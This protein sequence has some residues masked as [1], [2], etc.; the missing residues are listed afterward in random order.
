M[1]GDV[2]INKTAATPSLR[3]LSVNQTGPQHVVTL[4][5]LIQGL[6]TCSLI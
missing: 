1:N 4:P 5:S 6:W 3:F 2:K